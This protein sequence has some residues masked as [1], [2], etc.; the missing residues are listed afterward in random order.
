MDEANETPQINTPMKRRTPTV[1]RT[2]A[3]TGLSMTGLSQRLSEMEAYIEKQTLK[4]WI[5]KQTK[6]QLLK[7]QEQERRNTQVTPLRTYDEVAD[8][9]DD[10]GYDEQTSEE[11]SNNNEDEEDEQEEREEQVQAIPVRTKSTSEKYKQMIMK[12]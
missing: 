4:K 3:N 12:R 8:D 10:E 1:N 11:D 9:A 5:K 6:A 7:Q 2:R